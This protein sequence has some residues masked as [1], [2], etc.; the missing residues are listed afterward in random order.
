MRGYALERL[1]GLMDEDDI[2][3]VLVTDGDNLEYL[4]G[5]T[6][7]AGWLL[8][9]EDSTRLVTSKF[10]RYSPGVDA[11][12]SGQDERERLHSELTGAA[13]V[14]DTEMED[15]EQTDLLTEARRI[16]TDEELGVM[17]EAAAIGDAAFGELLERFGPGMTEWEAAAVVDERVRSGGTHSSFDTLVHASTT[18][19]HRSL[20]DAEIAT[21]ETVL[22]DLGARHDGY[23]SDMT[24]MLP[25][26]CAG[27]QEELIDA[28]AQLQQLALEHVHA[29]MEIAEL[30]GLV[31]ERVREL[32]YS[33]D[34]HYLHSLGHG[35]GV[36]IHEGPSLHTEADGEL[37][38]NMV[39]TIE[40]G[41]YVPGTGGARIEDQ[42]VVTDDGYERLTQQDRIYERG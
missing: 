42:V 39:V 7:I 17:R 36:A 41:L 9:D 33:V 30:A 21:G 31:E 5:I 24:R 26:A 8:V 22:V 3:S 2:G 40:P 28:V 13:Q 1:R 27:D 32:G 20:R 16:K 18:E 12:Y 15:C 38:E 6:D 29:G 37:R 11:Y 14:A 23:C 25:N 10:F 4:T 34:D 19:P 35:V